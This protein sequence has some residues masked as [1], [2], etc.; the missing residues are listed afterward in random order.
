MAWKTKA[1]KVNSNRMISIFKADLIAVT[2]KYAIGHV[3]FNP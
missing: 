1:L 3:I 2:K